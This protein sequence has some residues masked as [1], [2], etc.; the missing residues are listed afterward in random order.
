MLGLRSA[1]AMWRGFSLILWL[2]NHWLGLRLI[3]LNGH[4]IWLRLVY[5][6]GAWG[7]VFDFSGF[8]KVEWESYCAGF[9]L[10]I[11]LLPKYRWH[12]PTFQTNSSWLKHGFSSGWEVKKIPFYYD[13]TSRFKKCFHYFY[14]W[15]LLRV[16]IYRLS[17]LIHWGQFMSVDR[18]QTGRG[19]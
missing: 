16:P 4:R 11:Q 14:K 6:W 3:I 9:F 1:S 8:W 17:P 7:G 12:V 13:F 10:K 19:Q 18:F 5:V 2:L 15:D